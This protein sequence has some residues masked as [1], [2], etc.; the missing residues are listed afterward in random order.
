MI[1][2]ALVQKLKIETKILQKVPSH[3]LTTNLKSIW[4]EV[5]LKQTNHFIP[6][7]PVTKIA[8]NLTW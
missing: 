5:S 8:K 7:T 6:M 3:I 2:P 1:K 4:R